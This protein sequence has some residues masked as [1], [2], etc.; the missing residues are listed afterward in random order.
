LGTAVLLGTARALGETMAVIMVM[1]NTI[2]IPA[3][4]LAPAR[5]LIGHI[6][7]EMAYAL[8]D[9][10]AA[11]FTAGVLLLGVVTGLVLLAERTSRSQG[12][13]T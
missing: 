2:Q 9:H 1:G 6:A 4:I 5:T 7:L 3:H 12:Y 13:G 11:L 8:G 10:R